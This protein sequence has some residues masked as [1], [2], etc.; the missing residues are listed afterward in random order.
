[1]NK[2]IEDKKETKNIKAEFKI[3]ELLKHFQPQR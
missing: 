3:R 1:M 2:K